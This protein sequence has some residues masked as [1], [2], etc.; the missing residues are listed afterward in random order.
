MTLSYPNGLPEGLPQTPQQTNLGILAH[1]FWHYTETFLSPLE[2][3][4]WPSRVSGQEF[5]KNVLDSWV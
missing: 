1:E 5:L 3:S 2:A 4:G